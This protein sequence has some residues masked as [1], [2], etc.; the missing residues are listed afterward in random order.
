[1]SAGE[2][3]ALGRRSF[4]SSVGAAL[5]LG[6]CS[7][8]I[9]RVPASA[10]GALSP[11]P[12]VHIALDGTVTI[13][14]HRSEM[15]QG[16]K[17]TLPVLIAD[18][19]GAD[20]SRVRIE[21][22]DG[23]E[24]YG[25]QNT[26][27]S[28]SVSQ[29][30]LPMRRV[31]AAA[32]IMLT[33]VAARRWG[34]SAEDCA[35]HD[36]RIWHA[37]SGRSLPFEE[38]VA[39]AAEL[40][41]PPE[42]KLRL[43]PRAELVH[44]GKVLPMVDA[45]DI[46]SG[47][48]VY[49]ADVRLDGMLTA[50]VLRPKVVG[51]QVKAFDGSQ[52][53]TVPGV[54]AV[55][56]IPRYGGGLVRLGPAFKPLGGVAVLADTTWAALR[57]RAALTVEWED[58]S[59]KEYD[60]AAYQESLLAT[61]RKSGSVVRQRGD[62][63]T[64]LRSAARVVTAEYYVPHLAHATMEPPAAVARVTPAGCEVWAS[65]QNPQA[66][67]SEVASALGLSTAK[68]TV[69]TT[70]VGGG[71]G[72]KS[73]PDYVVEAALL[74]RAAGAPVRVQWTREDD[75][76]HDYYHAVSAQRFD[77]G[78]AADGSLTAWRHRTAFPPIR[79]TF[80]TH[81]T[82]PT[83]GEL[84]Q[85]VTDLPLA[86]PNVRVEAGGAKAH[87]RIGWLRSVCNIFHAFGIGSFIDELAHARGQDPRRTWLEVL[88]PP[89]CLTE[90][91]A[92]VHAFENYHA[93]LS[94]HPI[95]VGRHRQ[96]IERVTANAGWGAP[97]KPGRALGLA[98]HRSFLSCIA[99]VAA[100]EAEPDGALRVDEVWVAAD[101]GTIANL[102]RVRAQLEGAVIFGMSIALHG[103]VT[104]KHGA[105]EQS[106][107]QDYRIVRIGQAPRRIHIDLVDSAA[108]PGGVGEPGVPPVAPAIAN[109][110]FALTGRRI[111]ALPIDRELKVALIRDPPHTSVPP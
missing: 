20:L 16:I 21:Q 57:G 7:G 90:K 66:A 69:H 13:V 105:V 29:G 19:L 28:A 48:A 42:K 88:G 46:V 64:A 103:G 3:A 97:Q 5:V 45:A 82:Q 1:M 93:S 70:L 56:E 30:F 10:Q 65:T 37:V 23:D 86:I 68:V 26:D 8:R 43:R 63:E 67:R 61:V 50:V 34:V 14:C 47:R 15:G 32:R 24:K 25:D 74:A 102:D 18:E 22:A 31:G 27:G 101:V 9:E 55:V 38:L 111:R 81:F 4:L 89:R 53:R 36:H 6:A 58:G 106:N 104:M 12:F 75:I 17:S 77:A 11:N 41:V 98:S 99:V 40:P 33:T 79:S 44:L 72:R 94:D 95:D 96:V 76:Q 54:R 39:E 51:A 52:A 35:A 73:K 100:L 80:F 107:F 83:D 59:N 109:A 110:V 62:V 78:I 85:G 2:T 92:G 108:P 91:E 71:F 49:G 87:V 60:S 84:G